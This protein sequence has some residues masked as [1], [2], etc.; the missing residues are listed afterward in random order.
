M[1]NGNTTEVIKQ[2][3]TIALLPDKWDHNRQYQN[4][5]IKNIGDNN[6]YILD[7]GCGTGELTKRLTTKGEKITGIDISEI[8]IREANKRNSDD[9]IEYI[10]TGVEEYLEKTD[11]KFDVIISIAALHHM[12]EKEILQKMKNVL[13]KNGKILVLDLVKAKTI[14]D[15]IPS[16]IAIP[17]SILLRLIKNGKLRPSTEEREAWAGHFRYDEYL[18]INEVKKMVRETLGKAKIRKHLFWRYSIIY[19]QQ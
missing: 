8:M 13:T 16:I 6:H 15:Y 17:L 1:K 18:S 12:D 10:C 19:K 5:L 4:Y 7:A 14:M 9:K 2:F 11:K 3:D